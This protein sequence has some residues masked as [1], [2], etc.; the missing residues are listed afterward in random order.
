MPA[1]TISI[2]PQANFL[3]Q[4]INDKTMKLSVY[5]KKVNDRKTAL[6]LDD[7]K[8]SK[9]DR[10]VSADKKMLLKMQSIRME[11][12]EIS[13]L[14]RGRYLKMLRVQSL[15]KQ[16]LKNGKGIRSSA[17]IGAS[18]PRNTKKIQTPISNALSPQKS[19]EDINE[20]IC[21]YDISDK[22]GI[23]YLLSNGNYGI[24]FNDRTSMTALADPNST[25]ITN[26]KESIV[27]YDKTA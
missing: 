22:Y 12:K 17:S 21:Y 1:Y 7:D 19:H 9:L 14:N 15:P 2:P 3:K 27:Y 25:E 10:V 5:P 4:Y 23:A 16:T 26:S 6:S 11:N 20:I 13:S 24:I 18:T 8:I